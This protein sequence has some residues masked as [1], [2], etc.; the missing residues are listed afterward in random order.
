VFDP[1]KSYSEQTYE[2]TRHV[3]DNRPHAVLLPTGVLD[4]EEKLETEAEDVAP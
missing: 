1:H 4:F 2:M 3:V